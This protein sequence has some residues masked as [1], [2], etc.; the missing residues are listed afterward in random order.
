MIF[1]LLFIFVLLS[2][3]VAFLIRWLNDQRRQRRAFS[4]GFLMQEPD[5]STDISIPQTLLDLDSGEEFGDD[6]VELDYDG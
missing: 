4:T 2:F 6:E 1:Y 5:V 3:L